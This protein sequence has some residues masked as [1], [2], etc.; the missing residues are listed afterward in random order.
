MSCSRASSRRSATSTV[1]FATRGSAP[2]C[3]TVPCSVRRTDILTRFR[4]ADDVLVLLSSEVG[5]EGVD[6]QFSAIVVNYDLPWNPMRL[7]QRIGRV[8]RLGQ[9]EKKV[10]ILNLIHNDTIDRRIYDRLYERL[11]IGRRALGELEAVL[12]EPMRDI[13][14]KLFDPKLTTQQKDAAIEQTAHALEN[15]RREEEELEKQAGSLVR[16]GDYILERIMESRDRHRWLS[17]DDILIYVR[18]RMLRDFPGTVIETSP[19]GSMT[20]RI[21]LSADAAVAFQTFLSERGLKHRTR[22]LIG[23]SRQRYRFTS[24]VVQRD[25]RIECISQLHPLVRFAAHLDLKDNAARDAQ[26]VAARV[27]REKLTTL[28]APGLYVLAAQR[29]SSD[30]RVPTAMANVQIGYTGASVADAGVD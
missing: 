5:S 27:N 1:V 26:V 6:L 15:R 25:G 14:I 8:D 19:P 2:S 24:S 28:C 4:D 18:D 20:Y 17:G 10:T 22:L 21:A 13:T 30:A 16:H 29:W 12:G 11:Q 7:E 23:S 3:Y 9:K